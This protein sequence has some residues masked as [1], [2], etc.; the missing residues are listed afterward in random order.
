MSEHKATI[1]WTHTGGEFNFNSYT[2]NHTWTF[3]NG[4][5][6]EG[7][8]AP[9]YKGDDSKTDPEEAFVASLA[10]CHML[11]FLALCTKAKLKVASY[12]DEA[13]GHLEKIEGS[14]LAITRVELHPKITFEGDEPT[15]DK[16]D[17]LHH[18]AHDLCFIANSVTTEVTVQ[19][20]VTA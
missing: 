19:P 11:T 6:I 7:S 14:K 17:E 15:Q 5:T 20:P 3:A 8:A 9:A 4:V 10:S 18:N 13:V 1:N 12:T 2:R 16:L